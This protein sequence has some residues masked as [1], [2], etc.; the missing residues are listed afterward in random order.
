MKAVCSTSSVNKVA[1]LFAGKKGTDNM[2]FKSILNTLLKQ[3]IRPLHY[4][5]NKF[6]LN[7]LLATYEEWCKASCW[8]SYAGRVYFILKQVNRSSLKEVV[9]VSVIG[10]QN[11]IIKRFSLS[12]T[13][14]RIKTTF[15]NCDLQERYV[16]L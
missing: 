12:P 3:L 16:V 8:D 4:K 10:T 13:A 5:L 9:C 7:W 6:C 1:I 2:L 11:N 15:L 14:F